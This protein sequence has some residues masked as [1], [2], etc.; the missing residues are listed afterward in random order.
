MTLR[1]ILA[2]RKRASAQSAPADTQPINAGNQ[3]AE[4][5]RYL[6]MSPLSEFYALFEGIEEY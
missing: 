2:E 3:I 1:E 5:P 4:T 6:F